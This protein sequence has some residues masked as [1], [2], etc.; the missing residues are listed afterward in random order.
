M[1]PA[2]HTFYPPH[3][4]CTSPSCANFDKSELRLAQQRQVVL[5]TFAQGPLPATSVHLYC[6]SKRSFWLFTSSLLIE[7]IQYVIPV[8][9]T[10]TKYEKRSGVTMKVFLTFFR[11]VSINLSKRSSSNLGSW[12][13]FTRGTKIQSVY[14]DLLYSA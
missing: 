3:T 7:S 4:Q 13:C 12:I 6:H 1:L 2:F 9:G 14:I 5:F 8:T 10:I 11:R